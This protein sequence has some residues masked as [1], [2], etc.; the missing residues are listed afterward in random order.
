MP[1]RDR[2]FF[3]GDTM[4]RQYIVIA[5]DALFQGPVAYVRMSDSIEMHPF[6]HIG[7]LQSPS[8]IPLNP[9]LVRNIHIC[10]RLAVTDLR[11][12]SCSDIRLRR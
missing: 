8:H 2:S 7:I 9:N 3:V 12:R 1:G 11:R 10:R 6:I 5:H 4:F